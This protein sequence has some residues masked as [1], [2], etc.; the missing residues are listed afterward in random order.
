[1]RSAFVSHSTK[2]D[3][4]VAELESLLRAAGFDDV[5]NDVSSIKPD[6]Q[7]WPEIERGIGACDTLFVVITAASNDSA[8]VKREVECARR[9]GK[10]VVPLWVEDC[11][12]PAIFQG[13]DVI[14]LRP[15]TRQARKIDISSIFKYAPADLIGRE[16]ETKILIDAWGQAVRAES[17]RPHV[18]TFVALGGEGKTSLVAKWAASLA[19][20]NW[21]GCDAVFAW[22]FYSQGTREQTAVS[23]DLFLTE[24]LTFF[25]DAA[26]AGS[27][28][29]AFE[30]GRRLAQLVGE[31]RALLILDGLEPLQY[32]PTSPTPGELKDQGLSAL[33]KGLAATSHGLCVVT[34]RYPLPD[35]RAFH[36]KTVREEK[37]ARLARAAGVQLLKA[38][39]V[40]GSD[41]RNL[42]LHEGDA[43]SELVS[44][45]EKL[46]EDVDG[47]A[48][49]L[50]IMGSFLKKAFGGDI[51]KRDRVTFAK[52]SQRTDNGHAFRAM[53]AYAR[54]MEDGSDEARR[55]LAIL[56]LMGLFDRPATADCL[57][58][59]LAA[60]AIP[61]LTE[62]L[63][64]LPEEDWNSSLEALVAAKLLTVS[65]ATVSVPASTFPLPASLDAH[66]LI[67]EYFAE[68]LKNSPL[69]PRE[70]PGAPATEKTLD[71]SKR[72]AAAEPPAHLAERDG[73]SAWREAHRRLYEHLC[74]STQEGDQPTLEALQ[75]LY[76]AVAHG[77]QAG[78]QQ[79]AVEK[80]YI[81]RINKGMGNDGFYCTKK[82]GAFGSDLGAVAC[83]FETPWSRVS[84]SLSD[85]AQS[86]LLNQAAFRLRALGRLAEALEPMRVSGEMD[87]KVQ[88]WKGAAVSYSNLSELELTL[89]EVAG[90]VG[91]AEQSVT[92]ADRSGDAFH[93]ESKRTAHADSLHQAGRRAEAEAR[94]R[95]AEQMQAESQPAYPLL[96][97][98]SGF[99]YC[100][101]L[102][103]EAERAAWQVMLRMSRSVLAAQPRSECGGRD[104]RGHPGIGDTAFARPSDME[105][106]HPDAGGV[107]A[108]GRGTQ[109][110][111]P[112][113]AVS[114]PL[115]GFATALQDAAAP[116]ESGLATKLRAVSERTAQIQKRRKGLPTYS[117]LDIALDHLT[118]GRAALY[119]AILGHFDI[120]HSSFDIDHT[121]SGLRRAGTTHHIPRGLLTRAWQ[122]SLTGAL[123]SAQAGPDSAQSDL[124]EAWEIAERGPM[125]LFMAD[126]RLT[127]CRLF[128]IAFKTG[129]G[130]N[131][132]EVK[133]PWESPEKDLA[134]ARKLIVACGYGRRM[135]ELEDAEKALK[136]RV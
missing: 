71:E 132:Q 125:P 48:L 126:I 135:P 93:R 70:E 103:A 66:P 81:K 8:W 117:L 11:P 85:P 37:L 25:G 72:H 83:F 109:S 123:T 18:L 131:G 21:P 119:E 2:D 31:R 1:M 7:F 29:G 67:R 91:D 59:L 133:Y 104:A 43:Q 64:G 51:R 121:V 20:D 16:A 65:P 33:L 13:R 106:P 47:H 14:D 73:Y 45:F 53:A 78:L 60:P 90:A 107:S 134:E 105:E 62:P 35:L 88:E 124:D 130:V 111:A 86:W 4:Y 101:L 12:V 46:V 87:V 69:A 129:Q 114:P 42:P 108:A 61:G 74:A 23:S 19:H 97:G 40:I 122:R 15:R 82:L 89:G 58:A 44:E 27:A 115:Q 102:L 80:V 24:A 38:H 136:A 5:F 127:R 96:Y 116:N 28:Q 57:A 10:K 39:G 3:Y 95:E 68:R 100:D 6:E 84:P 98:L 76:Q 120:C 52:A 36:G 56:R 26:M 99:Q 118:L 112:A 50:H 92:Y 49:T 41:R 128:G 17:N 30:K 110:T 9:L 32:A 79:E 54:W 94:F 22:S 75:P 63:T 113:K 55:E 34:T 77:C